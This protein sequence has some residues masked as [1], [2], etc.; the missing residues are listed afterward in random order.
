MSTLRG[1]KPQ[2]FFTDDFSWYQ[3]GHVLLWQGSA[4][5][6]VVWDV[7]TDSGQAV[8]RGLSQDGLSLLHYALFY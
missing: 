5:G 3:L 2:T 7:F 6:W 4:G 1:L 8:V